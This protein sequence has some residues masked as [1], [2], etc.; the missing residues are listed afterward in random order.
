MLGPMPLNNP[1][2]NAL[3]KWRAVLFKAPVRYNVPT[4]MNRQKIFEFF[5]A[6]L[7]VVIFIIQIIAQ[8]LFLYWEFWW[9]DIVMHFAGGFFVGLLALYLYYYSRFVEPKHFSWIFAL[10]LSLGATA[11]VGVLWELFEFTSDQFA[12]SIGRRVELQ[13]QF[14]D[15]LGDLFSDLVGAILG[16]VTYLTLWR[17]K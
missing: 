11:L 9:F 2:K 13:Q 6:G 5:L 8:T 14:Q 17:K 10:L 1:T 4:F 12:I 16:A 15:T 3:I 7:I